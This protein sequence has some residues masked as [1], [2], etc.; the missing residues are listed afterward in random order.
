MGGEATGSQEILRVEELAMVAHVEL[1]HIVFVLWTQ[2]GTP[3]HCQEIV[4][5]L[6]SSQTHAVFVEVHHA[7]KLSQRKSTFCVT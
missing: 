3:F 1:F 2:L 4:F 6:E 7:C 5:V